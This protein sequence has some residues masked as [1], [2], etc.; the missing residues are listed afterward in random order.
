M[1]SLHSI[2]N[3]VL[4]WTHP[5]N[6]ICVTSYILTLTNVTEGN[7]SYVYNASSNATSLNVT[8]LNQ[9]AEYSFSVA[10]VDAGDRIGEI[11][12][13][14]DFITVDSKKII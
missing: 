5:N 8:D 12:A 6:S 11:S 2:S 3:A 7:V 9:G 1:F 4:S 13:P 14:S 10:G